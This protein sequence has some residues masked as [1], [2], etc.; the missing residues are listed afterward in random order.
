MTR[1]SR[2]VL[3]ATLLL[4]STAVTGLT[5]AGA[6]GPTITSVSALQTRFGCSRLSNGT[7]TCSGFNDMGELGNGTTNTSLAPTTVVAPGGS[8]P[9]T[10]VVQVVSGDF[11]ACARLTNGTVDCWGDNRFGQ[12]GN[13][14]INTST[15]PVQVKST[16]GSG[17]LTGVTQIAAGEFHT[18][19]RI[20]NGT[21]DCWGSNGYFA[22]GDGTNQN[23]LVPHPVQ[24]GA[25]HGAL[26]GADLRGGVAV[27][28]LL[29]AVRRLDAL[30]GPQLPRDPG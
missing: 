1:A 11:Y 10:G 9:L 21:I 29:G 30:L 3:I 17:A 2:I 25:N 16:S 19:A 26:T 6:A 5:A 13:G 22:L 14:T 20:S 28:H 18:C 7:A 4:A 12:L 24:N 15:L 23:H 27:R 8:G